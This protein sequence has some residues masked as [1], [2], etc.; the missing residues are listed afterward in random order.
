ME[1]I[2]DEELIFIAQKVAE[3]GTQHLLSF[4]Q[5]S[6]DHARIYKLPTILRALPPDYVDLLNKDRV[7]SHYQT[8]SI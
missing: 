5:T 6:K 8:S 4:L 7:S 3:H 2:N 1:R